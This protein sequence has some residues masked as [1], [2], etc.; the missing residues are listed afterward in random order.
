MMLMVM[1]VMMV[2][3]VVDGRGVDQDDKSV[4]PFECQILML[5]FMLL[6]MFLSLVPVF[7]CHTEFRMLGGLSASVVLPRARV[8]R[9]R[10]S[11][12]SMSTKSKS[13][14]RSSICRHSLAV[15]TIGLPLVLKLVLISAANPV[16][17]PTKVS[18]A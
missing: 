7:S 10:N 18:K 5:A 9:L 1:M 11:Q 15:F 8:S 16:N 12:S 14:S 13:G 6:L 2:V 17:L 3:A 4:M